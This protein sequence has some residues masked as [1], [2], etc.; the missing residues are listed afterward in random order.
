MVLRVALWWVANLCR[1]VP[2]RPIMT[3]F[4][5]LVK[6][7]PLV[8]ILGRSVLE[9]P[10]LAGFG[11]LV[12]ECPKEAIQEHICLCVI[13]GE[14]SEPWVVKRIPVVCRL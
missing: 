14:R 13:Q 6:E 1:F 9:H 11:R 10:L 2:K 7:C 3:N 4:G 12:W 8:A 5:R